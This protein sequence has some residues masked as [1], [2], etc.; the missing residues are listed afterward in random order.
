M[1][2]LFTLLA[3]CFVFILSSCKDFLDK[4]S[5]TDYDEHILTK[6]EGI[7]ALLNGIY[8]AF[9]KDTYYGRNMYGYEGAKGLDFFVRVSSG[10]TFER[11]NRYSESTQS[12][13]QASGLWMTIYGAIR[14][15]TTLLENID[16]TQGL[17]ADE[18]AVISGE[19]RALRA[20]AY[21]DLMRLFAYPPRFSVPGGAEYDEQYALGLPII[22]N[23]DMVNNILQYEIRRKTAQETYTYIEDEFLEAKA[24]LSGKNSPAGHINY[25]AV[26]AL[27]SR[28]YL[29]MNRWDDV[30]LMG[31]EALTAGQGTYSLIP[32]DS[33]KT[34]YYKANNSENIWELVYNLTDNLGSNSLNSLVRK[35]THNN[36]G[37]AN[38]GQVSQNLGYAAYGLFPATVSFLKNT[39]NGVE[40][41]RGYLVC[42]LGI[43]NKDYKG[44]RKYVGEAYH[45]VYNLPIIR[46][47]EIYLNL[48]E[49]YLSSDN[50]DLVNAEK[51]YNY[52]RQAR[53]KDSGFNSTDITTCKNLVLTER[54][55]ELMLEGHTYWDYFRRGQTLQRP[56]LL[57]NANKR[58]IA[59]GAGK[60]GSR[61]QVIYPIP[62]NELEANKAIRDQQNFGYSTYSDV[63]N[64]EEN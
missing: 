19:A 49:A 10:N 15:S 55:R 59:F 31:E 2:K 13:G 40:D 12:A 47:P 1:K 24:M 56:E 16:K 54:R 4:E 33:Y 45:F 3:I 63:Y 18:K 25:T 35:P 61:T 46:L 60:S 53:V 62:L 22:E 27:L 57:E 26:C 39:V 52:I 43:V 48:A 21:F 9:S 11:E 50:V 6:P 28:L 5:Y 8:D 34:T 23:M 30:I 14:T 58:T 17:S 20:L 29:Y 37:A 44:Y 42:D 41:V 51:Y 38:D 36:P 7:K 64:T 32:Y